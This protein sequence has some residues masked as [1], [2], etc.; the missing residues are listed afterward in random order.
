M[1]VRTLSAKVLG[2]FLLLMLPLLA[3]G[4]AMAAPAS[5]PAQPAPASAPTQS[6]PAS[7]PTPDG[8]SAGPFEILQDRSDRVIA[9]LP[10][11]MIVV[12]QELHSA[13]VVSAQVWVKTGSIY[14][15][16]HVGAGLSHFLEHLLVGNSTSKRTEEQNKALL[17]HIG[18]EVN[19][20]T[21]LDAVHY[22]IN[23]TAPF[24][25]DAVDLLSDWIQNSQ[26]T[27]EE[28]ARE[29][30][31]I[32]NEFA[33]G[34]GEPGRIFWKLTLQTRYREHPARHPTIGY[35]DEYLNITREEIVAFYKRMYVPN[36]IVFVVAGDVDRKAVLK[37]VAGLWAQAPTG[38]LPE[39]SFPVEPSPSKPRTAEG[40]ADIRQPMLRLAWPGTRQGARE[41][42]A[43][44]LLGVILGEG[45]AGRLART[46]RDAGLASTVSAYNASF[47]W[48]EGFFGIDA[49]IAPPRPQVLG[50]AET[51]TSK[52]ASTTSPAGGGNAGGKRV[53]SMVAPGAAAAAPA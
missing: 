11:R 13:P 51:P 34:Q 35:L 50:P 26:I 40:T 20:A 8:A 31:V 41:D 42:E 33:M 47:P 2:L 25:A 17:S 43:L 3:A 44:D 21:G 49:T 48:G 14:E 28:F 32:Q 15:Q 24:A 19:A 7:A 18:A 53:G 37:Q 45:E 23:T 30:E 16:E 46:V 10:N 5:A 38:K 4:A 12:V 52:P 39:L 36:N 27:Q 9:R 6:A 22:Y 29:R 1:F